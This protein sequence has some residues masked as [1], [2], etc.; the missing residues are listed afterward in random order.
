VQD[1]E[2]IFTD[3]TRSFSALLDL[4]AVGAPV[5]GAGLV[6]PVVPAL[7]PAEALLSMRPV[8]STW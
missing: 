1:A 2:I 7:D 6:E 8:T 3:C 4:L 5:G